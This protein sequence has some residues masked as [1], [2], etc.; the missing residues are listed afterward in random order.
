M[1]AVFAISLATGL[2]LMIAWILFSA[3]AS[4]PRSSETAFDPEKKYGV[5]GRRVVGGLV[6]FGMGG[7]SAAYG[8]ADLSAP[9]VITLACV[10]GLVAIWWSGHSVNV[11]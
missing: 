5:P 1:E 9:V 11:D 2:V 8:S 10:A 7:L 3:N 4:G 6:G